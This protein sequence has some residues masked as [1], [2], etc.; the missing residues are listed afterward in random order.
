MLLGVVSWLF[1]GGSGA[2][3]GSVG[4]SPAQSMFLRVVSTAGA[5]ASCGDKRSFRV[6]ASR[7]AG[8]SLNAV[9]LPE[10]S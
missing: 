4:V 8:S 3:P 6:V 9:V 1:T 7:R 2:E 5:G 10:A